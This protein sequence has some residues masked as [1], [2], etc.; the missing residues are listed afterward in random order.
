MSATQKRHRKRPN[1][2]KNQYA[3]Q[4]AS[5]IV[6][7]SSPRFMPD[8]SLPGIPTGV[9]CHR[10]TT[11]GAFPDLQRGQAPRRCSGQRTGARLASDRLDAPAGDRRLPPH[12]AAAYWAARL[13]ETSRPVRLL[14]LQLATICSRWITR[15]R[16]EWQSPVGSI[17][18]GGSA[19][20]IVAAVWRSNAADLIRILQI[21]CRHRRTNCWVKL[22]VAAQ[23]H[24]FYLGVDDQGASP[25][26][27]TG[28]SF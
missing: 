5:G 14:R 22:G 9:A 1:P 17:D 13:P 21:S 12:N 7:K 25:I 26:G 6:G 11:Q 3:S 2:A 16:G 19:S 8:Q 24:T 18:F 23:A 27:R 15:H 20:A 4:N 28:V 10:Q